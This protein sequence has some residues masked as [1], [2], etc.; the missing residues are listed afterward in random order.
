VSRS[1]SERR[2]ASGQAATAWRPDRHRCR[3]GGAPRARSRPGRLASRF[4]HRGVLPRL[5]EVPHRG[6]RRAPRRSRGPARPARLAA[7]AEPR[8]LAG[9]GSAA[10]GPVVEC[11]G[12]AA[13]QAAGHRLRPGRRFHLL[14]AGTRFGCDRLD[15][16]RRASARRGGSRQPGGRGGQGPGTARG[17]SRAHPE[18]KRRL[19]PGRPGH[20][21]RRPALVLG[22][23]FPPVQPA[24]AGGSGR[25]RRFVAERP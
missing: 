14:G 1:R 15:G 17:C 6:L 24:S 10:R 20:C 4:P 8:R 18:A 22:F 9:G 7:T 16:D 19:R 12:P 23:G 11:G 2:S 13:F 5:I 25:L 21:G 3:P